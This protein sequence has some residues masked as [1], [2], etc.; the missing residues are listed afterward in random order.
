MRSLFPTQYNFYFPHLLKFS[1]PSQYW[2]VNN[3]LQLDAVFISQ[4]SGVQRT[5]KH[6]LQ[7]LKKYSVLVNVVLHVSM[8]IEQQDN[9]SPYV[10]LLYIF[11]TE[12]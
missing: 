11:P 8:Q 2:S 1:P 6:F 4:N 5:L 9:V 3:L 12:L 7:T 10:R